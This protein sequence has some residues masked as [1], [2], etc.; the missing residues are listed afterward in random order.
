M[1]INTLLVI[2]L[3]CNSFLGYAQNASGEY[4]S[5]SMRSGAYVA[6]VDL[7]SFSLEIGVLDFGVNLN[8][9]AGQILK[10]DQAENLKLLSQNRD[11][12]VLRN[13][14]N[15]NLLALTIGSKSY[16]SVFGIG[17]RQRS[18]LSIDRDLVQIATFGFPVN[19]DG[20]YINEN[21]G[22]SGSAELWSSVFYGISKKLAK[23]SVG[24][25]V[26]YN[27]LIVG[28]Q[29]TTDEFKFS[30]ISTADTNYIGLKYKAGLQIKGAEFIPQLILGDL[31]GVPLVSSNGRLSI[32]FGFE[33]QLKANVRV[34]VSFKDVW[35]NRNFG[36]ITR[37]IW[38]GDASFTGAD[39]VIGVDSMSDVV[40]DIVNYDMNSF[41]PD[42]SQESGEY[43]IGAPTSMKVYFTTRLNSQSKLILS[44]NVTWLPN[45]Q[46]YT[47]TA[48]VYNKPNKILHLGYGAN[49]WMNYNIIDINLAAKILIAPYT[50]LSLGFNNPLSI[51]RFGNGISIVEGFSG[52]NIFFGLSF[53][54]YVEKDF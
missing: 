28:G 18:D 30:R 3:I 39:Y 32:D 20:S 25:R 9:T 38:S 17:L 24:L 22:I 23:N 41:L 15:S 13:N 44:N 31:S 4:L 54:K 53:G 6:S 46:D 33:Q 16:H 49:W 19:S 50:R 37:T 34:G 52:V 26:N 14:L 12:I 2:C 7:P 40:S 35:L 51:P 45:R 10:G 21:N 5:P 29:L 36:K 47:L 48:F 11:Y 8:F 27:S 1:R 43:F 42:T